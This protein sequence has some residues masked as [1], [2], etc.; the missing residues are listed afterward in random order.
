MRLYALDQFRTSTVFSGGPRD[1]AL[2]VD[3]QDDLL[4]D[5]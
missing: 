5:T 1:L 3:F 2:D 4:L